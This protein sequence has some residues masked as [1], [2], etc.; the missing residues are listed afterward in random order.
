LFA[1]VIDYLLQAISAA[2]DSF[3]SKTLSKKIF[4]L[5]AQAI[6]KKE[7]SSS[8]PRPPH[9]FMRILIAVHSRR[10]ID[11]EASGNG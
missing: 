6:S 11:W 7:N 2:V 10:F 8:N 9:R 1:V 4:R 3:L 5:L